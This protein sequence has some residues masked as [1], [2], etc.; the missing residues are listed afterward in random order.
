MVRME[1]KHVMVVV[2]DALASI[3]KLADDMDE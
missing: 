3:R 2:D 1:D